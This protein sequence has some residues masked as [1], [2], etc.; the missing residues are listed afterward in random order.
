MSSRRPRASAASID[1]LGQLLRR[2]LGLAVGNQLDRHHR[3]EPAHVADRGPTLPA[4]RAC[5][6][7]QLAQLGRTREQPL[8]VDDIEHRDGRRLGDRVADEGAADRSRRRSVHELGAAEHT[9]E[10]QSVRDRL[11]HADEVGL[12]AGVL[13]RKEATRP[14]KTGLHLIGD[15][16]DPVPVADPAHAFEKLGRRHD[17]SPFTL[18]GLEDDRSDGLC[19][20]VGREDPLECRDRI[21]NRNAPV[22]VGEGGTVDLGCKRAETRLV[23]SDLRGE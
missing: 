2:L 4:R 9:R 18:N 3:T 17:E 20:N 13:H 5:A 19:S 14:A 6:T 22:A 15:E 21:G 16:D 8:L 7:D 11:R 12:D 10:R 23:G 1:L